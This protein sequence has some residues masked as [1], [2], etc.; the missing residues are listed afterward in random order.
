MSNTAVQFCDNPFAEYLSG[1]SSKRAKAA[2]TKKNPADNAYQMDLFSSKKIK[3]FSR[4]TKA[5]QMMS[6][7]KA[8]SYVIVTSL[9]KNW[10]KTVT[11]IQ[12][13]TIYKY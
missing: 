13:Y 11:L 3:T 6:I 2:K 10:N 4:K 7:Q 8:N 9:I 5:I 1:I 12:Y